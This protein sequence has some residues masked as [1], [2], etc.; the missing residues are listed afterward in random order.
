MFSIHKPGA[1]EKTAMFSPFVLANFA[2]WRLGAH[3]SVRL[4]HRSKPDQNPTDIAPILFH[5]KCDFPN[6]SSDIEKYQASKQSNYDASAR[7]FSKTSNC[8]PRL[9]NHLQTRPGATQ[10]QNSKSPSATHPFDT[11][12]SKSTRQNSQS[13]TRDL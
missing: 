5:P 11:Y 7:A 10:I 9:P 3:F 6:E 4:A 2:P 8:K 12:P 13:L 1:F